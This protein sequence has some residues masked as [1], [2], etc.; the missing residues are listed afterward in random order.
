MGRRKEGRTD[1]VRRSRLACV[2]G[3]DGADED[4]LRT[5]LRESLD[6]VEDL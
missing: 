2:A 3:V 1:V 6:G 5:R 4:E